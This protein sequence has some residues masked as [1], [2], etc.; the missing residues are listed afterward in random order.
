MDCAECTTLLAERLGQK[1]DERDEQRVADHLQHCPSC[2]NQAVELERLG[3]GLQALR[4][5]YDSVVPPFVFSPTEAAAPPRRRRSSFWAR[6]GLATAAGLALLIAVW[7][8]APETPEAIPPV[9]G[10]PQTVAGAFS[11]VGYSKT[12][13]ICPGNAARNRASGVAAARVPSLPSFAHPSGTKTSR[14]RYRTPSLVIEHR[15][16]THDPDPQSYYRY[17]DVVPGCG[18]CGVEL[19]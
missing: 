17:D 8:P 7:R 11:F 16:E 5:T 9:L 4:R 18:A 15:R 19:G 2:A 6:T 1:L 14:L 10:G 13:L 3:L 12:P